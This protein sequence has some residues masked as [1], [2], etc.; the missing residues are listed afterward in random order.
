MDVETLAMARRLGRKA[1]RRRSQG[2]R[3]GRPSTR[4]R[5]DRTQRN[6]DALACARGSNFP[7]SRLGSRLTSP[8]CGGCAMMV[9]FEPPIRRRVGGG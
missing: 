9:A 3:E 2:C 6:L 7:L 4:R 1:P 8:A 5:C